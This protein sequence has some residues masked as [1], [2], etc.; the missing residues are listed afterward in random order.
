MITEYGFLKDKRVLFISVKFFSLEKKIEECLINNGALVDYYDERPTN[1]SIV[2]AVIRFKKGLIEGRIRKYYLN[3][4]NNI[5]SVDYDYLLV[6]KGESVPAFF[7]EEFIKI[8]PKSKRIY[9]NWDSFK[10]NK[11]SLENLKYFNCKFSFDPYD[12]KE[13]DL[14]FRP[15]FFIDEFKKIRYSKRNKDFHLLSISTV[16]SDRYDIT[17][18]IKEW[19]EKKEL[20]HYV[21]FYIQAFWYYIFRK[22]FDK[23]FKNVELKNISFKGLSFENICSL[24]ESS[25]VILDINHLDQKGLTIRTFE[26]IGAEKKIITT[27]KEILKYSFYN[28][29]NIIVID[30]DDP[31]LGLRLDFFNDDYE[32]LP[33]DL[34]DSLSING[35]LKSLFD[36]NYNDIWYNNEI[37]NKKNYK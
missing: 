24:Y 14:K 33:E 12:C 13:Y 35:W 7:L 2:K 29:K 9:Y 26:A 28:P 37:I 34:Y 18:K 5:A 15:L 25:K 17:K 6:N 27:N 23:N 21:F 4:L 22:L 10:N 11:Y 30:R 3:I 20:K 31:S 8:N 32:P 36:E 19:C 1:N 16:H